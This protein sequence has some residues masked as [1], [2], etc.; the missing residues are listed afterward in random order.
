[1]DGCGMDDEVDSLGGAADV[2]AFANIATGGL[3][4][5]EHERLV[6]SRHQE[7]HQRSTQGAPAARDQNPHRRNGAMR[8]QSLV[9]DN[10]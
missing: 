7:W 10:S 5:I 8:G 1:M 6:A 3:L 2:L 9:S 4:E